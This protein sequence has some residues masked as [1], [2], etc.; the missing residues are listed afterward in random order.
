MSKHAPISLTS[1]PF[2]KTIWI[3]PAAVGAMMSLE[4]GTR[5][6]VHGTPHDVE[7]L[8]EAVV[9]AIAAATH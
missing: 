8:K 1:R 9:K 7:E 2:G 3:D 4:N 5:L 6:W